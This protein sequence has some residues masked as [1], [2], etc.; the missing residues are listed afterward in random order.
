MY[1]VVIN[2]FHSTMSATQSRL[3][4]KFLSIFSVT[5][6]CCCCSCWCCPL[7][8]AVAGG[9]GGAAVAAAVIVIVFV[10]LKPTVLYFYGRS[11][12]Q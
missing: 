10:L 3:H 5:S 9:A 12:Y 2:N 4:S 7:P 6:H 8:V 1:I 11:S